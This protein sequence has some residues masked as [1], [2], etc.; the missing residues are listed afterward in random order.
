MR[1]ADRMPLV[2]PMLLRCG[3]REDIILCCFCNVLLDDVSNERVE[4]VEVVAV[5]NLLKEHFERMDC[6]AFR[7]HLRGFRLRRR[8]EDDV[9]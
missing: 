5:E 2:L 6:A 3:C 7:A 4:V 9:L 8:R 1:K